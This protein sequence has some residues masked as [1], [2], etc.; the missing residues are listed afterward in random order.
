MREEPAPP[1]APPREPLQL[2]PAPPRTPGHRRA[3][4]KPS[5]EAVGSPP[6]AAAVNTANIWRGSGSARG[7]PDAEDNRPAPRIHPH[8]GHPLLT[9]HLPARGQRPHRSPPPD[10]HSQSKPGWWGLTPGRPRSPA[11]AP[12]LPEK[13]SNCR[14]QIGTR[15]PRD[16]FPTR[17]K[18]LWF[19]KVKRMCV[20]VCSP[21][22]SHHHPLGFPV[23][24]CYF[25]RFWRRSE[26]GVGEEGAA[27][28]MLAL[29]L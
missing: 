18:Y 13:G 2:R 16:L 21:P 20:C 27:R 12:G 10:F 15:C 29:A 6:A 9:P 5:N 17:P 26:S 22:P 23:H 28:R 7:S 11:P 4:S 14:G 8:P 25:R 1:P 3:L 19:E 24:C